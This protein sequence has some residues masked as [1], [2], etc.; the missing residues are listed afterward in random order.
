MEEINLTDGQFQ[1]LLNATDQPKK[2]TPEEKS[3]VAALHRAEHCRGNKWK[4]QLAEGDISEA[5]AIFEERMRT[6]RA[7][8]D[9]TAWNFFVRDSPTAR[10]LHDERSAPS[11]VPRETSEPS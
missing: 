2:Y 1:R 10:R 11:S 7:P 9:R 4:V 6:N 3:L 5:L 8:A